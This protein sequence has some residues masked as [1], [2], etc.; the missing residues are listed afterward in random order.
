MTQSVKHKELYY[1]YMHYI[2]QVI[3]VNVYGLA[4]LRT[5]K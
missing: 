4:D 2:V 1:M 3:V 5:S